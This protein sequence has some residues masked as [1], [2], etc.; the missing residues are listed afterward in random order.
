LKQAVGLRHQDYALKIY[1]GEENCSV[2]FHER[3]F[4]YGPIRLSV[5]KESP[6]HQK[7]V[8]PLIT[9]QFLNIKNAIFMIRD[10]RDILVSSFFSFGHTHGF[11]PVPEIRKRE[12]ENRRFIQS[13][14][15][16][17]YALDFVDSLE[18]DFK[19]LL[20]LRS[21]CP[22]AIVLKYEEMV[23]NWSAFAQK[24]TSCL[25]LYP[26]CLEEVYKLSRPRKS[27]DSESHRRSGK[28]RQFETA[29]KPETISELNSK[30]SFILKAC[31]Y[32]L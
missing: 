32:E 7:F 2:T 20:E 10:P 15:I 23:E 31:N 6:V 29:L 28:T 1:Q 8:Y 26:G 11:S 25:K 22:N 4:V 19:I 13:K 12:R 3:G 21:K 24:L 17:E 30:L 27:E 18:E 16:D 5:D 14:T 9:D